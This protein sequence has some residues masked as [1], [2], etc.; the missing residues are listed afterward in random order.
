MSVPLAFEA[1]PDG[2]LVARQGPHEVTLA[3]GRITATVVDA[4]AH[5]RVSVTSRLVGANPRV[6]PEGA[7]PLAAR[8]NYIL[9]NDPA[10]WRTGVP[11][12]GRAVYRG[13]YP[14][15]DLVFHGT[16]GAMEYDFV[17][18][19]GASVRPI[20]FEISGASALRLEPD[21]AL[22]IATS[23]GEIHWH[24]PEVYQTADGVR[25]EVAGRFV[26]HG[27]RVTFALGPYDHSRS[28]IID[29]TLTYASYFGGSRDEAARGIAVDASGNIYITGSTLS[30]N[31]PV[32]NGAFQT[33]YHGGTGNSGL[34]LGG[35]AFVAKFTPAGALAYVTYIGG[36]VDDG[37]TAI[38]VDSSGNAYI[39]G[40]TDSAD[41]PTVAGSFQ[42]AYQG[43][44]GNNNGSGPIGDAFVSKLNAAGSALVYSTYLGGS[45]DDRGTAIAVDSAGNAYIGGSTLSTNFP[46]KNAYQATYKGGG[47]SPPWCCTPPTAFLNLGDGFLAKLNP[48]GTGL[49]FST[50]FGGSLDDTVTALAIDGAG[51]VYIGGSTLST[52]LP[53]LNAYQSHFGGAANSSVQPNLTMG[54][55]WVAKFNSTGNLVFS[56]YLGGSSDDAVMG[57]AIDGTGAVYVTGFTSSA[58]FPVTTNAAQPKF[59]GPSTLSGYRQFLWGDAF[60]AK[61][62]PSGASL[63]YSTFIGGSD[64]DAGMAIAVDFA[65]NA[66]VGGLTA[67]TNFPITSKT[68]QQATWGGESTSVANPTGDGFLSQISPDG[69]AILY[70]TY[71]GGLSDD[72]VTSLALNAQGN[73]YIAGL[74]ASTNLQVTSNAAQRAFG[75]SAEPP[76]TFGDGFVAV[77]SGI[78]AAAP[79]PA[80]SISKTHTGSFTQ[81]QNGATYIVTVSNAAGA[82]ATSGT[83]TVTE[84]VP[85]GMT[86]VSMAG[87]GWTC[88]ANTCTRSDALAAGSSYAAITVTVNVASNAASQVT[89]QAAV[90]GGGSASA[91]ASDVTTI[92]SGPTIS[93]VANA[94]GENPVIAPNTW[95]EI[96]G[97]NL[98]P[99]GDTRIWQGSDF[100]GI[101][102]PTQLDGVS[103]T[104]NGKAAYVYYI[105]STQV[106]VLTPPDAMSGAVPVEVTSNGT[107]SAAFTAQA[108][109][110]SPSFFVFNGGPYVAAQHSSNYSLVGP[111]SL[112]P[113][114]TTPAKPGETV[115]IYANGFG[116][117]SVPVVSGSETQSGTLSPLPVIQIGGAAATVQF[118]GLVAPGEFQFNVVVPASLA[119][120]DQSITATYN[121]FTT[122]AGT[123]ITVQQ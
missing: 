106:N 32:T 110:E 44:G 98:A 37:G 64:H 86:L 18:Q 25:R 36:A 1:R 16:A 62:S 72:A 24:K 103:A 54:D 5:R 47:G 121:G 111:T 48:A 59:A 87:T 51:N 80:L 118:A 8:A 105:S 100:V 117:T 65:G 77:F 46:V 101:Q 26:R 49:V 71:Y 12:F 27:R 20:A 66:Y 28:L 84:T 112:Y 109:A 102:M 17:V 52:D 14:G 114:S 85:T 94:E 108:Q 7:E 69:S 123:L 31:L 107:A 88:A 19:P 45:L 57:L 40:Y 76:A 60:A 2:K 22:A 53:T 61:L 93:L 23:A 30:N 29:P 81:G 13:L 39:T 122:Q 73:L 89:N 119:N 63:V 116:P 33:G 38:A 96:K 104:V 41:F 55:G 113:G 68:A 97:V 6:R 120:G 9:G 79:T 75:G 67:S 95:V 35:D 78:A 42:T 50:Y 83:V 3:A 70:S 99:A 10:Q 11:L 92:A 58:D 91:S 34:A 15:V 4:A 21:G 43:A 82:V 74:T 115:I 56:T 90:S